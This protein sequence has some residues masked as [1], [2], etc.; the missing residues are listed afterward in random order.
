[1]NAKQ[2]RRRVKKALSLPAGEKRKILRDLDEIFRSAEENGES[3]TDVIERLGSPTEFAAGFGSQKKFRPIGSIILTGG[4]VILFVL[5]FIAGNSIHLEKETLGVI[6]G[7]DGPTQIYI[8]SSFNWN[9]IFSWTGGILLLGAL[10][11]LIF[12]IIQYRR[13]QK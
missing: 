10:V 8:S 2:Y 1:M 5:S 6:G 9:M 7:A 3:E 4:A 12:S 13:N 11:L